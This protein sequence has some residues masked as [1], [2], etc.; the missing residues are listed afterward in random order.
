[1]KK[2]I[3]IFLLTFFCITTYGQ[4]R[5]LYI[6]NLTRSSL[7]FMVHTKHFYQYPKLESDYF[8]GSFSLPAM[9]VVKYENTSLTNGTSLYSPTSVPEIATWYLRTSVLAAPIPI[10]SSV[11]QTVYG[12]LQRF[13]SVKFDLVD[14][15]CSGHV[16]AN[17]VGGSCSGGSPYVIWGPPVAIEVDQNGNPTIIADIV[18]FTE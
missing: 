14:F 4:R 17:S 1:M 7:E 3:L 6:Y 8:T 15:N 18:I 11:A 2:V 9:D 12:N 16:G 13:D 5:D 10:S